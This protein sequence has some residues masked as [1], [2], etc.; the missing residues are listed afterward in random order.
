MRVY[1]AFTVSSVVYLVICSCISYFR[2]CSPSE[3]T[4]GRAVM[5]SRSCRI[6]ARLDTSE[7]GGDL[8]LFILFRLAPGRAV[9]HSRSRWM[10]ARLDTSEQ[11]GDP[12]TSILFRLAPG[13]AVIHS[14][15]RWTPARL[16]TN[17]QRG[18][19][20]LYLFLL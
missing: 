20:L 17:E 13:R 18:E 7:Q 2:L 1:H 10:P 3:S 12:Y 9:M 16:D 11:G 14:R 19:L 5:H 8:Y 6:P 4:P 15:S